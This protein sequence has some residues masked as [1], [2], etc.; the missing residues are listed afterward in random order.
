VTDNEVIN[1]FGLID[2]KTQAKSTLGP[3][4]DYSSDGETTSDQSTGL[5]ILDS[6]IE[7]EEFMIVH[8]TKK[9]KDLLGEETR[10]RYPVEACGLLFGEIRKDEAFVRKIVCVRNRLKSTVRF[11]IDPEEFLES[12]WEAEKENLEHIGFFHSHPAPPHPSAVDVRYMRFWPETAW[13]II[14]SIDYDMAVYQNVG[15]NEE[16][17]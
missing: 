16:D 3:T 1:R 15:D 2:R 7:R 12:L 14:S 4:G 6:A 10:K 11:Q 13:L 9:Q 17:E 5:R 8:L